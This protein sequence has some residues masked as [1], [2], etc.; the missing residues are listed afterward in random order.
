MEAIDRFGVVRGG[1]KAT[2]RILRCHPFVK[3]G[4]DPVTKLETEI[5]AADV[6]GSKP[7]ID[8][9]APWKRGAF[10]AASGTQNPAGFSPS[11]RC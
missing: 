6:C 11:G 3:G 2:A 1:W 8:V 5:S 4:Y 7:E 9:E 10:S